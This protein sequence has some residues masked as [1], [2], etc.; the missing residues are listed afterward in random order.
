MSDQFYVVRFNATDNCDPMPIVVADLDSIP[1]VDGHVVHVTNSRGD[2]VRSQLSH[3]GDILHVTTPFGGIF[4]VIATDAAGHATVCSTC[5]LGA[6]APE[7][8][9]D[10]RVK[11]NNGVGNGEDPQ[12]PGNPGNRGGGERE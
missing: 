4:N 10:E 8:D 1:V 11:G 6:P 9:D 5:A 12:P 3:G 2:S 7:P